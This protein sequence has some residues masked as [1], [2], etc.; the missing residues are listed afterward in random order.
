MC[1]QRLGGMKRKKERKQNYRE[2][3]LFAKP[4]W[5]KGCEKERECNEIDLKLFTVYLGRI[6]NKFSVLSCAMRND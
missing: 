3:H 2:V 1:Y 4:N 5:A 6:L